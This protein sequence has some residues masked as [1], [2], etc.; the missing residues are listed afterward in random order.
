MLELN[1]L[2][3]QKRPENVIQNIAENKK[4]ERQMCNI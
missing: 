4:H 3:S 1:E 2:V